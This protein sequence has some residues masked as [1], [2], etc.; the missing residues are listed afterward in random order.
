MRNALILAGLVSAIIALSP[1]EAGAQN[2]LDQPESI[3]YDSTHNRYL[4]SNY[5]NGAIVQ[6][7]RD[8]TQSYF[9]SDLM[10]MHNIAGLHIIGD[11][12]FAAANSGINQ[13]IAIF[14]LATGD[15][16]TNLTVPG[17]MLIN[18]I[19]SDTSGYFYATDYEANCIYKIRLSDYNISTFVTSGLS[20]PNGILFDARNNR[21]L[22]ISED[23]YQNPLFSV[24]LQDS[25]LTTMVLLQLTNCDG[26][27]EDDERNIY[28][29]SW[30]T[31]AIYRYDPDF[32]N[33]REQIS[34]G[35]GG[36]AD[37]YFNKKLSEVA[38]PVF[39]SNRVKLLPLDVGDFTR[40]FNS[41]PVMGSRVSHGVSWTD[42]DDDGYYD[43]Y[44]A[45]RATPDGQANGLFQNI[46]EG[47]FSEI[48]TGEIVND[49]S[50]SGTSTWGDCDNDG[51]LDVFVANGPNQAN[52]LYHNN[53]DG[54]F[55][56]SSDG[57]IVTEIMG[58]PAASWV[59]YDNDG[60]L[61]LFV[62]NT[63]NNSLFQN[64]GSSFIKVMDNAI[65]NESDDS[66]GACWGDYNNDGYSDLFVA[67]SGNLNN[68]LFSNNGDGSFIKVENRN[69]VGDG[70]ESHGGSW[71]DYDNDGD[72]DLF[73]PNTS[74]ISGGDNFLYN[75]NGDGTFTRITDGEIVNDGGY[76]YGSSWG[77]YDNDG[78]LD[79][80]VANI[81]WGESPGKDF[82][83]R[84]N[85]DGS[86]TKITDCEI[87]DEIE[88]SYGAAWADYDSDGDLDL[89]V[90][91]AA[92]SGPAENG[93][94]R[95]NCNDNNWIKVDCYGRAS[96]AAGIGVKV[97]IKAVIDGEPI[98]QMREISAQTGYGGQNCLDV[99]FGLGDAATVDSVVILWPS[100]MV[101]YLTD[102]NVNQ[103]L[104]F[105]DYLCG[106]AN[107]DRQANVADAV[108]LVNYIFKGGPPPEVLDAG[109]ANCEGEV[110]VG[111]VVYLISFVFKGGPEPC[112]P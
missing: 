39:N 104:T 97:R 26:L 56:K 29:S 101:Q 45:N 94:Y 7:E 90:A 109:D 20:A 5:G 18:D 103:V 110:N 100:G 35:Y 77:D 72:L 64:T 83:Y 32:V 9:N 40:V 89:F 70:G 81:S 76:S 49:I 53:G 108:F 25:T 50:L 46:G 33:P 85:G 17:M 37:I 55:L 2:L 38:V 58:S 62:A 3:V 41:D 30:T 79:L 82:L 16:V 44:L 47:G 65:V 111:D 52:E 57:E 93:F 88:D 74:E 27:A 80:Y 86:F 112:C 91:R 15:M 71:G 105:T 13:G 23:G 99:H 75:N 4:V 36:P 34:S 48:T 21:L 28:F 31:G 98:W 12:L 59:D 42:F 92:G 69:I 73:V 66:Y 96:N 102:V 22:V 84:N 6:V 1:F 11:R 78:D 107:G 87:V 8:L 106:D 95:N 10:P 68:Q 54:T 24:S 19:T 67:H 63:G 61:D 14:D 43:L 51:D 60:D